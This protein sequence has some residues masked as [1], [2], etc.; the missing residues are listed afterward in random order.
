M[1][2]RREVFLAIG[3][4]AC[5]VPR[6][7]HAQT[8]KGIPRVGYLLS[9]SPDYYFSLFQG[10]MR[11][12]GY[13]EGVTISYE[14]RNVEGQLERVPALVRELVDKKV[15]VLVAPNNVAI[16]ATRKA[17][18]SIPIVMVASIDPVVAG[19]VASL[20]NPG[21][22]VTGIAN[23][24]R[25]LSAKRIEMLQEIVPKFSRLAIIWD[26]DGP[27]PQVAFK[28]YDAAA[29]ALR[30]KVQSLPIRGAQPNLEKLFQ[31]ARQAG[32]EAVLVVS[33]PKMSA[34]RAALMG[35]ALQHRLPS[36]T[37][38]DTYLDAGALV[39]YGASLS[40]I[41][42]R[43]AVYVDKILKGAKPADLPVEHPT[44][45]DLR[46]N[47]KTARAIGVPIPNSILLRAEKIIE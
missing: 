24:Q 26:E 19:F 13:V 46:V 21:G 43:M 22:N 9:Q 18:S 1:N 23:L 10:S 38:N 29:R 15:S 31:A 27:G 47:L 3:A 17:T 25:A 45:F 20:A 34:H 12:L 6:A 36:M 40:E 2:R 33:N 4:F 11:Q 42:Q 35:L 28:N 44:K 39:S 14:Q 16:A 8:E 30:I 5:Q 7:T 37:E 32:A 41:S